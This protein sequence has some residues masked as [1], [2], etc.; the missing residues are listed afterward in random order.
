MDGHLT[1]TQKEHQF[2]PQATSNYADSYADSPQSVEINFVGCQI[3]ILNGKNRR[4]S[5]SVQLRTE[6][7]YVHSNHSFA[8]TSRSPQVTLLQLCIHHG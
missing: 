1:C 8:F 4:F 6:S 7:S 3:Q 2:W 5:S